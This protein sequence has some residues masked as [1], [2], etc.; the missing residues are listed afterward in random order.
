M[1]SSAGLAYVEKSD[2][3][4]I[5]SLEVACKRLLVRCHYYLP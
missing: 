3:L 1:H 4:G 5:P 2:P